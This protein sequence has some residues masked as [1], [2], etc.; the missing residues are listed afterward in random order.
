MKIARHN[1]SIPLIL[2]HAFFSLCVLHAPMALAEEWQEISDARSIFF[3]GFIQ[4][5]GESA[6]GQIRPMAEL[7]ARSMAQARLLEIL[8]GLTVERETVIRKGVV[9]CD[10]IQAAAKGVLKGASQCGMTY[11]RKERY[12]IVCLQL[13]L[14]SQKIDPFIQELFEHVSQQN[15]P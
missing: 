4:V 3:N 13:H 2:I 12:A 15:T 11:D 6:P 9:D 8:V 14:K 10:A 7:A 1:R 5:V